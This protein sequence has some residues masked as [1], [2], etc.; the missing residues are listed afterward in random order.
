MSGKPTKIHYLKDYQR[1]PFLVESLHLHFRLDPEVTEVQARLFF[2]RNP[3]DTI[4]HEPHLRLDGRNLELLSVLLDGHLLRPDHYRQDDEGLTILSVPDHG[5]LE[6]TTRIH[7]RKNTSLEGLFCSGDILCTQCEPEGLRKITFFPDRPDIMS[8]YQV[9]LEA[10]EGR[11]STLLSNGN[12]ESSILDGHGKRCVTW[13]DPFK[14][15]SYLFALVAGNLYR[16]EDR[17]ITSSGREIAL[18]L[19]VEPENR[20]K[21]QHALMALKKSMAWDERHFGREYDLDLY[22]IVAVNDFNMGAMENKGLNLFNAKYVLA[23]P[24]TATDLDYQQIESVIAHEYFHNWTGNRITCRDW[25]QLSLK[26]GLTVY[27]DQEFSAQEV[28]TTAIQRIDAVRI[29]RGNQFPE[30]TGPTAHPVQPDS[31]MEINNFYTTTIYNKGAEVVRM[32]AVLLGRDGFR[33]GMDLYFA[34]HDGQAVTVEEFQKAMADANGRDL[35]QFSR[36]YRQAGT[37]IVEVVCH[38]DSRS[39]SC[40][41]TFSQHCPATPGQPTKEPFPIPVVIALLDRD[42]REMPLKTAAEQTSAPTSLLFELVQ[43]RQTLDILDLPAP[44]VPSI[45]RNFSA[46]VRLKTSLSDEELAFLWCH[47][48]DGFNRWEGGQ[49]LATKWLLQGVEAW[50]KGGDWRM[51][52][53][54][55]QAFGKN[56]SDPT[57]LPVEKAL[58]LTLPDERYLL[59]QMDEG[60]PEGIFMVRRSCRQHLA[61]TFI[62]PLER[63][64]HDLRTRTASYR[65][66]P[67]DVGLRALKN[68]CLDYLLAGD[69]QR[70]AELALS[71]YDRADNMTD[72]VAAM[73]RLVYEDHETKDRIL[74]DFQKRWAHDPLV[75]DKWF[76]I[77]AMSP[78]ETTLTRVRALTSH[79]LFC[80]TNPNKVR[81]LIGSFCYGNPVRFHAISGEG[82]RFLSERIAQL[83]TINPQ[84]AARLLMALVPWRRSE[85][86]RGLHMRRALEELGKLPDLARDLY[87]LIQKSLA[88]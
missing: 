33:R 85:K 11:Y 61:R 52:D 8:R 77:Q 59:D 53:T 81:A 69:C 62:E 56:L 28:T 42:G 13:R 38:Y 34:R 82:Y 14:K 4:T 19:Y 45:L 37:P 2:S 57:L 60:E 17:L 27:R 87:E 5:I 24:E 79:P 29:L 22:M 18:H 80:L 31:Y 36:W 3:D 41:L 76:S 65:Y 63:I 6:T 25:F 83:N 71:Q 39:R 32:L 78:A 70:F 26:E 84:V 7:P 68:L 51:D 46:P 16:A 1:P 48:T 43:E 20:N 86:N 44:P 49:A 72:R 9:T 21:C 23:L 30:D 35:T 64:Y 74:D 54:F 15:P 10:E 88:Q 55:V 66:S 58:L 75:M 12:L 73:V 47:D 50:K 67:E 40:S